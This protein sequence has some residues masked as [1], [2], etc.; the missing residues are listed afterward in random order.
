MKVHI[1]VTPEVWSLREPFALAR[2]TLTAV[3]LIVVELL[4]EAGCVGRG[5]A[6]G[7]PYEGETSQSMA[8]QIKGTA[9]HLTAQTTC[10]ELLNWLPRGGA[11]NA[12]DCALWDLASK[13]SGQRAWQLADVPAVDAVTTAITLGLGSEED[14]RRRVRAAREY[15]IIKIK[16]DQTRHIVLAQIAREEL[17]H[18]RLILDANQSWSRELLDAI[19][20]TLAQQGVELIEQP[21]PVGEDEALRGYRGPVPVA[22]DESCTDCTSL[23]RLRGLYQYINIKLDKCGGLTE[24]LALARQAL[25]EGFKLMV[26]NMGGT[27]LSMAPHMIVAQQCDYV[28]LDAPLIFRG[29]RPHALRYETA[30]IQPPDPQLWG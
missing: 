1:R 23:A 15:P 10:A 29:D 11:R 19:A 18:A 4:D 22:A 28:D 5:E 20:P 25:A 3:E 24:G 17:P 30:L 16:A 2:G 12:L 6:P 21:V 27:S 13:R 26:G 8:T 14:F 9:E 7:L